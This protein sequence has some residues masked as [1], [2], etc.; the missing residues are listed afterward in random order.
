MP[1]G[2]CS[3]CQTSRPN[4]GGRTCIRHS[5]QFPGVCSDV[6]WNSSDC[7]GCSSASCTDSRSRFL[8]DF[9][10]SFLRATCWA[11]SVFLPSLLYHSSGRSSSNSSSGGH[12]GC[13]SA[14]C[15]GGSCCSGGQ[16][17]GTSA[18][19]TL[20]DDYSISLGCRLG[21]GGTR[22]YL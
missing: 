13:S 8:S 16:G 22:R 11:G 5:P 3:Q 14:R 18:N 20:P 12:S 10:C 2:G 6:P 15:Q 21:N 4:S 1:A 19:S 7:G 9:L 17:G